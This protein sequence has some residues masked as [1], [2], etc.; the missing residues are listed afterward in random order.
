MEQF[1]PAWTRNNKKGTV[2]FRT[3]AIRV[4]SRQRDLLDGDAP[5]RHFAVVT[6]MGWQGDRLLRWQREK[7]GTVELGHGVMKNDLGGGVLPCSRFGANA[8][9]WRLNVLA[10]NLLALMKTAA[11]PDELATAR[12]KTLRFRLLNVAG[13]LVHHAR[14][15][16]LKLF[17]GLPFAQ[18]YVEARQRLLGL[19]RRRRA[20]RLAA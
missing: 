17:A 5:W 15:W 19:L 2:P 4:R 3:I 7:Q 14:G 13:R 18:A 20:A 1:I 9:W 10:F 6:N 8:A 11:L 12:P 16:V